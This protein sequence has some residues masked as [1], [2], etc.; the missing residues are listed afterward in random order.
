MKYIQKGKEPNCLTTYKK[1]PDASFKEL[2]SNCKE[3]IR[4]SLL[5]EQ[6]YI[7]AYC[8][9]PISEDWN[10]KL[11]KYKVEIEHFKSQHRHPKLVLFYKNML[12]V[13]NGNADKPS[14][15]LICDKAKSGFDKTYD[16]FVNPLEVNREQQIYYTLNGEIVSDNKLINKDLN[17]ILNLNEENLC[18]ERA[19]LYQT[20]KSEI[21]QI[22]RAYWDNPQTKKSKLQQ[23]KTEWEQRYNDKF[24][25]LCRVPL[26]LIEKELIK[27]L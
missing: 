19:K 22:K 27:T 18:E 5:K 24:R 3:A 16:L 20:T 4:Q 7:C 6:G 25:P 23:L 17:D 1:Q 14:H 10:E 2:D 8:M 26:Y 13:C 11:N 15:G 9:Q 21:K 12:A